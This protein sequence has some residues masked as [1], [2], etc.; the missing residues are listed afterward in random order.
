MQVVLLKER[1]ESDPKIFSTA[2]RPGM[3]ACAR[4]AYAHTRYGNGYA[5]VRA[6][7]RRKR[8]MT[9]TSDQ[10]CKRS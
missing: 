5:Y 7:T 1:K 6:R 8:I 10:D 9:G 4:M 2:G 3:H